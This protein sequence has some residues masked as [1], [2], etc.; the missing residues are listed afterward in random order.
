M[1]YSSRGRIYIRIVCRPRLS[2]RHPHHFRIQYGVVASVITLVFVLVLSS[3]CVSGRART[4]GSP[5]RN[6]IITILL[7]AWEVV[8]EK[9]QKLNQNYYDSTTQ[10]VRSALK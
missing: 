6:R 2:L 5:Q 4:S 1:I 10:S 8:L 3:Y 9:R 7:S